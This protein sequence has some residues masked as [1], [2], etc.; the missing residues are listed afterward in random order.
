MKMSTATNYIDNQ[1]IAVIFHTRHILYEQFAN[2]QTLHLCNTEENKIIQDSVVKY[3][4]NAFTASI[5]MPSAIKFDELFR[6]C[7][8]PEL[9]TVAAVT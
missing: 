2:A 1:S 7:P 3:G 5:Q 4:R 8:V 6:Q 9:G